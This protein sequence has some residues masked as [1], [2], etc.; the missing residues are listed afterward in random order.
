VGGL[1]D[2]SGAGGEPDLLPHDEIRGDLVLARANGGRAT[3]PDQV[4]ARQAATR[5]SGRRTRF[6][7]RLRQLSATS[8]KGVL[9]LTVLVL[10]A[11]LLGSLVALWLVD[12]H[13]TIGQAAYLTLINA[14]GGANP[15]LLAPL[16]EQILQA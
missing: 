2:R 5:R 6:G 16:S 4:A 11:I 10:L 7:L 1:A 15:D 8:V 12:R 14:V 9:G 13:L 3:G